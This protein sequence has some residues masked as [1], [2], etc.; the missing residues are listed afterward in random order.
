MTNLSGPPTAVLPDDTVE[1]PVIKEAGPPPAAPRLPTRA[2]VVQVLMM[3]GIW[4]LP[5]LRPAGPGNT[6]PTDLAVGLAVLAAMLWVATHR[7]LVRFPYALPVGI[8]IFAGTLASTVAFAGG[9]VSVGGGLLATTQDVFV[10]AWGLAIVNVAREAGMLR[11]ITRAWAISATVWAAVMILGVFGHISALSGETARDGVRAAFTLGDPNLAADYFICSLFVLR[12]ARYPRR[13]YLRWA[14]CAVILTAVALTG[15]NGGVLVLVIATVCGAIFRLARHRGAIAAAVAAAVLLLTVALA[16][17]VSLSGIALK[18]Q[19]SVPLLRDSIG[20]TAESSG[21]RSTIL[22]ETKQLFFSSDSLLGIGPGATKEAFQQHQ[23]AY[24]KMAHDDY[25]A[26]V[27]ERGLLGGVALICLLLMVA[28]RCRRIASRPLRPAYADI[29]PRPE[30]LGAAAIAVLMSGMFYQVLHFRHVWALF[31]VI[32]ALDMWGRTDRDGRRPTPPAPRRPGRKERKA[33]KRGAAHDAAP[34]VPSAPPAQAAP[35][36]RDRQPAPVTRPSQPDKPPPVSMAEL[37]PEPPGQPASAA[38]PAAAAPGRIRRA[39]ATIVRLPGALTANVAARIVALVAL[40][41]ATILVAHAGGPKLLG[42]LTLLRVLP[43]LAGVLI[44]C[45]LPTAVPY[46]LAGPDRTAGPRLRPTLVLL[47]VVGAL[48]ASACWLALTPVLHKVFFRPWGAGV[49]IACAVP[50][51]T[52]LWVAVGKSFL[53]GENDMKAAN[54]AIAA[55][56]AAFLPIYLLALPFLH[57]TGLVMVA[58]VGADVLVAGVIAI[59]L[60]RRGFCRGWRKPDARLGLKV[61]R[62]GMRAQVGGAFTLLNLRLDVAILG[63]LAGPAVLGVYA[64]ASK[65]AEL[66]RL[67]GL[68]L[69]YV[70]YPRLATKTPAEAGRRVAAMLPRAFGLNM[71][72]AV[73][74]AAAVPLL[75]LIYGDKFADAIIPAFILLVGLVGEGVAGVVSAYLYGVGRPGANSL[76]IGVAVLVTIAL[77][78]LLIPRYQAIGA[79][80]ASAAAYLTSTG[81]LLACYF[82]VRRANLARETGGVAVGAP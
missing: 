71:L 70:L 12:A 8:S 79:G 19:A 40:T 16:P 61:C 3:A 54:W 37:F 77:D 21:S 58:L 38:A 60:I 43:G 35:V 48:A 24:V 69:T 67:P 66:L 20:R 56:E 18:A 2:N 59:R 1:L 42:E 55:E 78:V 57:G 65:Y 10:L 74:L 52:Q 82:L 14:C 47:L 26:A 76:G 15:S 28:T 80:F 13:W 39:V 34:P 64:V 36:V 29:I 50:V 30:L 25:T 41:L 7:H 17:A 72:A 9:Y 45:G 31:G 46:F 51:F 23:Y 6:G 5:M 44:S 81:A 63:A 4:S 49:V 73:P 75:P 53:Q 62:Y 68:A 27:V 32:A 22:S 11:A 33:L